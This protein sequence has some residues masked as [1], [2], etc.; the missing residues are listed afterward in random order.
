MTYIIFFGCIIAVVI[1][2]KI[3]AW[4]F[5][6]IFKLIAN[7]IIGGLLLLLVNTFGAGF[8]L[9]IPFNAI[10]ALTSGIFGIP[11]VLL[12]IVLQYVL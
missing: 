5:K 6:I 10:T 4:P 9:H 11:G 1:I 7:I 8:G 12:L 3:L 2:A